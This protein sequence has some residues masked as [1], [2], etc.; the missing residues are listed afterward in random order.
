MGTWGQRVPP[1]AL[2][3]LQ[4][5]HKAARRWPQPQI[6]SL[7]YHVLDMHILLSLCGMSVSGCVRACMQLN[8]ARASL[9][10]AQ[11]G[12]ADS[13]QRL[14]A[15][16]GAAGTRGP[17]AG[18]GAGAG[19]GALLRPEL[20]AQLV[21]DAPGA[22]AANDRLLD[23]ELARR[24]QVSGSMGALEGWAGDGLRCQCCSARWT[25]AFYDWQR[26]PQ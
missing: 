13:Q 6:V 11:Q 22:A 19:A 8:A 7:C 14:R 1:S 17:T 2:L 18:S 9:A 3:E 21:W 4:Y 15:A 20:L 10:A 26:R 16:L 12:L 23:E 5:I 25:A 24:K